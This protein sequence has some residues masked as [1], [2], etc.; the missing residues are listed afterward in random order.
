[1]VLLGGLAL[2]GGAVAAYA[3]LDLLDADDFADRAVESLEGQGVRRAIERELVGALPEGATP[4]QRR[5]IE[6]V[7]DEV[8][9][10]DAFNALFREATVQLHNL[11]LGGDDHV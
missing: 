2:L 7:T 8:I 10:S 6:S 1:M 4:R 9:R 11:Y 5:L 3:R